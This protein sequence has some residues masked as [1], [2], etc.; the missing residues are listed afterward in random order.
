[1]KVSLSSTITTAGSGFR[2]GVWGLGFRGLGVWGFRG[3]G[4]FRGGRM[5]SAVYNSSWV[6]MD[7]NENFQIW[8][9]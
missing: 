6:L 5:K 2:V 1:M 8:T 7:L 3:F 9:C 4:G